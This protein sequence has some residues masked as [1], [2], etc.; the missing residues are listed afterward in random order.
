MSL[1]NFNR[2]LSNDTLSTFLRPALALTAL[3]MLLAGCGPV[4]TPP[5][6]A[7]PPAA[8][9]ANTSSQ[10]SVLAK[11]YT[12]GT[13]SAAGSYN[14]PEGSESV[15]IS[16]TLKGGVITD[17]TFQGNATNPRSQKF[18]QLF[19]DGYKQLVVGKPIDSLSLTVVNGAS[20]TPAGFMDAVSKIQTQAA[21][22]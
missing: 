5:D 1:T 11:K 3:G 12:D 15:N 22:A 16:L 2:T 8:T 19:S 17:S 10:S 4:A 18:Q 6:Q 9:S 21:K 7:P 20:L 13:F 14:S